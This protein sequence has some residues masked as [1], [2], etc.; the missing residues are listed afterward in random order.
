MAKKKHK[1]KKVTAVKQRNL[2][3]LNPLMRKCDTHE[4]TKKAKRKAEKM[5]LKR[6]LKKLSFSIWAHISPKHAFA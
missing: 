3:A 2:V 1:K 6:E 4:K 5:N